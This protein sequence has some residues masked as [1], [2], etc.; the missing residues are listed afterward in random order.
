[1]I[2]KDEFKELL[3]KYCVKKLIAL[4]DVQSKVIGVE[5]AKKLAEMYNTDIRE[6]Q[7]FENF[8]FDHED[9]SEIKQRE[10]KAL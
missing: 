7:V 10:A 3:D 5:D 2:Q 9:T 6:K 4:A 1:M 8:D